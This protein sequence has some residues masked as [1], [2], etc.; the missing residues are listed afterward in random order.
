LTKEQIK[1]LCV[2]DDADNSKLISKLLRTS[3]G[4][5]V[6]CAFDC[7]SAREKLSSGSYD[8]IT[9]DYQLPDGDGLELL[10]SITTTQGAPPVIMVTAHGGEMTAVSAMKLGAHG[11]VVK[12][13]DLA[14]R[15][16]EEARLALNGVSRP[17]KSVALGAES[18]AG[19]PVDILRDRESLYSMLMENLNEGVWAIDSDGNTTFVNDRMAVMLGCTTEEMIGTSLFEFT[20]NEGREKAEKLIGRRI[21]GIS[22][23]HDF[24]F[25]RRDGS[26]L[27]TTLETT[28]LF[29]EN[30]QLAGA[31]AA[32]MDVTG[33]RAAEGA[34]RQSEIRFAAFMEHL[35]GIAYMKDLE[36]RYLY[37]NKMQ[38]RIG[39]KSEEVWWGKTDH[40]L[41]PDTIA[42]KLHE[43]DMKVLDDGVTLVTIDDIPQK[44]GLHHWLSCRFPIDDEFGERSILGGI[45][46]DVSDRVRAEEELKRVNAELEGYAR[47]VSHDLKNPLTNIITAVTILDQALEKVSGDEKA[48]STVND[49]TSAIALSANRAY[50]LA[51]D[52]LALAE[53]GHASKEVEDVEVLPVVRRIL[54]ENTAAIAQRGVKV[55]VSP[56]LGTLMASPIQVYQLFS[57]LIGNALA[58]NPDDGLEIEVAY[59][60]QDADGAHRYKVRDGGAGIPGEYLDSVFMPFFK[61]S[62]GGTGIGL[63]IVKKIVDNFDGEITAY[64][65]GGACFEFTIRSSR[66]LRPSS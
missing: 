12:S 37:M 22:E 63:A 61:G 66:P 53:A 28:P 10:E 59:L 29:D 5:R 3:L 6:E 43:N 44:S 47:T 15:L 7:A 19:A 55:N 36:R 60:G 21:N 42:D 58:H 34:L 57:N 48:L 23:Q 25:V 51:V 46:I 45:S 38:E 39:S 17:G 2:E 40:D 14:A 13:N 9:L 18:A 35:P 41:W 64:N 54:T 8:L 26:R 27:L 62:G 20:D 49:L 1:V 56:E 52:L 33:R 32:V 65:D 31:L 24:E 11:Y 50:A 16:V 30:G 4:A